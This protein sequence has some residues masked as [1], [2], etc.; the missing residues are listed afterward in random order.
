VPA[1]PL[2]TL[3]RLTANGTPVSVSRS[4]AVGPAGL[5]ASAGRAVGIVCHDPA[6]VVDGRPCVLVT[7]TLDPRLATVLP[8]LAALVSETGSALS[9]LAILAREMNVPTVV[10]VADARARFPAGSAVLVDGGTGD[11]T[12]MSIEEASSCCE[13]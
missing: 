11:V 13:C 4:H 8:S 3:F 9:H 5:P 7:E 6:D 1:P 10:A 12:A 2:P